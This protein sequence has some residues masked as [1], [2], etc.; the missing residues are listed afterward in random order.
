M[1]YFS[2][3]HSNIIYSLGV[4]GKM[5][6]RKLIDQL[7]C[8]QTKS[9]KQIEPTKNV[10]ETM[11]KY[12][13]LTIENMISL[14][15]CKWGYK[16]CHNLLPPKLSENMTFDHKNKSIKKVHG[17]N[18][19]NK[20]TPNLPKVT[21]SK[22]RSSFLFQAIRNYTALNQNIRDSPNLKLFANCC[23]KLLLTKQEEH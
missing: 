8:V 4:W 11:I 10:L 5:I 1:L 6:R 13:I 16:L 14:E 3:I 15:Q 23:K 18:T 19:R 12:K 22:Y 21:G 7:T 2:Q 9:I 17:Y 20:T